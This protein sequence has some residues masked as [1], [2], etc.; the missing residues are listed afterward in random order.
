MTPLATYRKARGKP[1]SQAS[2]GAAVAAPNI[3]ATV[4]ASMRNGV[5]MH[6]SDGIAVV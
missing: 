3:C 2:N 4:G 1:S 6:S 5:I